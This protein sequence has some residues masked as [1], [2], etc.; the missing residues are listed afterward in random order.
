MEQRFLAKFNLMVQVAAGEGIE[1]QST[2]D[3]CG[4]ASHSMQKCGRCREALIIIIISSLL[5]GRLP[6]LCLERAQGV[7]VKAA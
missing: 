2:C 6:G 5:L 4:K 7:C 3:K 1:K